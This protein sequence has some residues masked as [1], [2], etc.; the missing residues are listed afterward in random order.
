MG[1]LKK[2]I[3]NKISNLIRNIIR[4]EGR[5]VNSV[6]IKIDRLLSDIEDLNRKIDMYAFAFCRKDGEEE[7]EARERMFRALPKPVGFM[8]LYQEV[9][10]RLLA[11][12]SEIC[13]NNGLKYWLW[14]GS[15]LAAVT[16]GAAIPWDD[17]I[18]VCMMRDDFNALMKILESNKEF[19]INVV[20]DAYVYNRQYRFISK[21]K[22]I[23]NFIDIVPCDFCS[24]DDLL[25]NYQYK[26]MRQALKD[27][28]EGCSKL[29]YWREKKYLYKKGSRIDVYQNTACDRLDYDQEKANEIIAVIDVVFEK[30]IRRAKNM[31]LLCGAKKAKA[32]AY[33][34][35]NMSSPI[36]RTDIWPYGVI[37]PTRILKYENIKVSVA[38]ESE[39]Y[40]DIC[41]PDIQWPTVP[42]RLPD[43]HVSENMKNDEKTIMAMKKFVNRE[44]KD[45]N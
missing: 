10:T 44:N 32:I 17:D 35:D 24:D 16:R 20:Y 13:K 9:N 36:N 37:F 43:M 7:L 12:L 30:Y 2:R 26:K 3:V 27:E 15:H 4:D 45:R 11:E 34:L 23:H 42:N 38:G 22:N 40:C 14:S 6:S 1:Y 28:F 21:E 41:F 29:D 8:S 31:G 33:G 19:Q 39:E 25:L 5:R 18:D